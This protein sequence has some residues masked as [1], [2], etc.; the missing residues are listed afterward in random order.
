MSR[1]GPEFHVIS[2]FP[3]MFSPAS[4]CGVTGK[5]VEQG[6]VGLTAYQLRDFTGGSIHPVD[7]SPYG[8]GPGMLMKPEP[9][10]AAVEQVSS[11]A[12]PGVSVLLTP[13]GRRFGQEAAARLADEKRVLLFCGRYEGVDERIR[14]LFDEELSIGDYVLSGGELA[15]LVI[16]DAVTRLVPGVLG[17]DESTRHE[18]FSDGRLE[19]PQY[20]RP[21]VFRGEAV[22]D[23]LRS[24]NHAEI[25]R[26]RREQSER[27]TRAR[28]PDLVGVDRSAGGDR[29]RGEEPGDD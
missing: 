12:P 14:P 19:Y 25:E 8:G 15:A 21:A 5:A 10:F 18:S 6:L 17:S 27:R 23:V 20:T 29:G 1:P 13:Q 11:T 16:I 24:G 2:L 7:D 4:L 28:R 26:W 9:V 3:E 22:P